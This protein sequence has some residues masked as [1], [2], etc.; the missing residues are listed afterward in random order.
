MYTHRPKFRTLN[1]HHRRKCSGVLQPK[2]KNSNYQTC[3]IGWSYISRCFCGPVFQVPNM[4]YRWPEIWPMPFSIH[5]SET[6]LFNWRTFLPYMRGTVGV[7]QTMWLYQAY[8]SSEWAEAVR[9]CSWLGHGSC[10]HS[11]SHYRLISC[12]WQFL[13]ECSLE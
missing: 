12:E 3:V 1:V 2:T 11:D 9:L 13:H 5:L 8:Y 4:C 10:S 6:R 7:E